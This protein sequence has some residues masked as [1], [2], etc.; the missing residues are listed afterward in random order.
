[1]R[2]EA[3]QYVFKARRS[4][5]DAEANGAPKLAF[6][7]AGEVSQ[8]I[9][10]VDFSLRS[11]RLSSAPRADQSAVD[12]AGASQ[13][14]NERAEAGLDPSALERHDEL[15][16]RAEV[17]A[18]IE[19]AREQ[20]RAELSSEHEVERAEWLE[21]TERAQELVLKELQ[22]FGEALVHQSGELMLRLSEKLTHHL[23][24]RSLIEDPSEYVELVAPALKELIGYARPRLYVHSEALEALR[25]RGDALQALHP[26]YLP[27]DLLCDEALEVGDF[28]LE[29]EGASIEGAL[30]RRLSELVE[31][32]RDRALRRLDRGDLAQEGE[33]DE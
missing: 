17:E 30:E 32:C 14:Q 8:A 20:L 15:I 7:S 33:E 25:E 22:R 16:E 1:M 12:R 31:R 21:R 6:L 28:R 10:P 19:R 23:I 9:A 18:L 13:V 5:D 29:V 2:R 26:D 27:L 4:D 24:R 11:A 3:E